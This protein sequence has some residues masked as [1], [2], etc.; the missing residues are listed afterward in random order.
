AGLRE[1]ERVVAQ[2]SIGIRGRVPRECDVADRDVG[3]S[4]GV[5][6]EGPGAARDVEV[7]GREV[8]HHAGAGNDVLGAG[9]GRVERAR[10]G[11]DVAIGVV[12]DGGRRGETRGREGKCGD[13]RRGGEERGPVAGGKRWAE[14]TETALGGH[15]ASLDRLGGGHR[16]S[17]VARSRRRRP[18]VDGASLLA[19]RWLSIR[20]LLLSRESDTSAFAQSRSE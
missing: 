7:P 13:H 9:E 17:A 4:R 14:E 15:L 11:A 1:A 19:E 5:T 2:R 12:V 18:S 8:R 16:R 3:G 10:P 6:I 20:S